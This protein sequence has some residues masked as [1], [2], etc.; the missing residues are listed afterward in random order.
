MD[1]TRAPDFMT[2]VVLLI[3]GVAVAALAQRLRR[4]PAD[5]EAG[6]GGA[7]GEAFRGVGEA[8]KAL[9]ASPWLVGLPFLL[10]ALDV[11]GWLVVVRSLQ[12]GRNDRA[13]P[14]LLPNI[15]RGFHNLRL[16]GALQ[17]GLRAG[18][19]HIGGTCAAPILLLA[20][21][22]LLVKRRATGWAWLA[23]T[24]LVAG[25]SMSMWFAV[26]RFASRGRAPA[27]WSQ[28][29]V[30]CLTHVALIAFVGGT[31][32]LAVRMV[33]L[34]GRFSLVALIDE[35]QRF[36]PEWFLLVLLLSV[37]RGLLG[38]GQ[39]LID[40]RTG[41]GRPDWLLSLFRSGWL[42]RS[43]MWLEVLLA[44]A[45]RFA[46]Y[47]LAAGAPSA[48]AAARE[49]LRLWRNRG[50]EVLRLLAPLWCL[51]LALFVLTNPLNSLREIP[52][53]TATGVAAIG[54]RWLGGSL[55]VAFL[56]VAEVACL[57][58]YESVTAAVASVGELGAAA[59]GD[60]C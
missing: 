6:L 50:V 46:P 23:W 30:P 42:N 31:V 11:A 24:L 22:V 29:A 9:W 2:G 20:G 10:A 35:L 17:Y 40:P 51:G 44:L 47:A 36:W 18:S 38:M 58:W 4:A 48:G 41:A 37:P 55:T 53:T 32:L 25:F 39:E 16:D 19:I 12:W 34:R 8:A 3:M 26:A 27:H 45:L 43:A 14:E 7:L 49:S 57:R 60:R 59:E 5:G 13:V 52:P 28:W 1:N 21:A 33:I 54:L 15:V 56:L